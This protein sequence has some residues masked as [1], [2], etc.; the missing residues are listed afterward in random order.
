MPEARLEQGQGRER[1]PKASHSSWQRSQQ[2]PKVP[3]RHSKEPRYFRGLV[4]LSY[5]RFIEL[6]REKGEHA[7]GSLAD[8]LE[9]DVLPHLGCLAAVPSV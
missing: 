7:V 5:Q 1:G 4:G 3:R 9:P 6:F 8:G 2:L